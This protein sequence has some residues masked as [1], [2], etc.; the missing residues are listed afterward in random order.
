VLEWRLSP[1]LGSAGKNVSEKWLI[2]NLYT[3]YFPNPNFE[4]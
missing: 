1:S 4:Y 2:D 3:F